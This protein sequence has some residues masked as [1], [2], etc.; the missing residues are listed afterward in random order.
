MFENKDELN[1]YP[2]GCK[3]SK[4]AS[5]SNE[6]SKIESSN[7]IQ[8]NQSRRGSIVKLSSSNI[9]I[10]KDYDDSGHSILKS[11]L[12]DSKE[13]QKNIITLQ[14]AIRAVIARK[15]I[16]S[17]REEELEWLGMKFI[18]NP[19]KKSNPLDSLS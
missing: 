11:G 17:I 19:H 16:E 4:S 10:M 12:I 9:E 13:Y 5:N 18:D 2:L 8:S 3:P 15:K 14:T 7:S 6:Q 1:E